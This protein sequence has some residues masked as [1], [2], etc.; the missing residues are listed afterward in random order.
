MV[1]T[2]TE[3]PGPK[4]PYQGTC[5]VVPTPESKYLTEL[6]GIWRI[7]FVSRTPAVEPVSYV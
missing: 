1:F 5:T 4:H 7:R 3:V 2:S 6:H